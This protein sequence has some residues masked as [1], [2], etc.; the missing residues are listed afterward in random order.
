[1][2]TGVVALTSDLVRKKWMCEGLL[3]AASK[4][5]W[6]PYTGTS[7]DSIVFQKNDASASEGHTVVFDFDGNLSQR[8][9]KGKDTA[10]GKGEQK[11]KFS[12]KITV[13]R[14]R[15]VVDNGDKF[16]AVNIGDLAISEHGD[17]RTKL[18]DLFVRFKDQAIFD[19]AQGVKGN[20]QPT[21]KLNVDASTTN[22]AYSDLVNIETAL[23]TGVGFK[24]GLPDATTA[25]ASR[26]PLAPYRLADGRSIWLMI[27]DPQTA[28]NI[29]S[30]TT[31]NSGIMAL[32]QLADLRG[33]DNRVFKGIIG[34]V[35]QLVLVEA[36]AFF[37]TSDGTDATALGLN[38]SD[39]EI[40]GMRQYDATN[41]A[42]SG[43]AAYASAEYS[44]NLILGAGAIQLAFGKQPDYKFKTSQDFDIK[45][46]SAV[47]FW[48]ES[49]KTN[50][51]AENSDYAKAKRAALD[52]GVIAFDVKL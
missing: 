21:H 30:N 9:I 24:S 44:R 15:L 47:E 48:M 8:A 3:Q 1:M 46:E 14:Y 27:I 26:A 7:K 34:Q 4:S 2:T 10:F 40:A 49:Q 33:N 6:S 12:D 23:R 39:I 29:K 38:Q 18:G 52:H 5:F 51:T 20:V 35:G 43:Q 17:S 42:W 31:A 13:E 45:S 41:S 11:K 25:A 16:D 36:E 50:L 37:G 19:T 28:A 22:L 32:A